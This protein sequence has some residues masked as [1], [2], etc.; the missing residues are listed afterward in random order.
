V[1]FRS[2]ARTTGHFRT[3][4]KIARRPGRLWCRIKDP[5]GE[6]PKKFFGKSLDGSYGCD[7]ILIADGEKNA[8]EPS[9]FLAVA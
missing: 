3:Y 9:D 7:K 6:Q 2:G 5:G 4:W 1:E 8:F